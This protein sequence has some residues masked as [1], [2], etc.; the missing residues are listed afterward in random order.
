MAWGAA[1]ASQRDKG[2]PAAARVQHA[3][4]D[5]RARLHVQR[6]RPRVLD[7]AHKAPL[8]GVGLAQGP[9]LDGAHGARGR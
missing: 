7:Q 2:R 5:D 4:P 8:V 9:L 6:C 1:N 3:A